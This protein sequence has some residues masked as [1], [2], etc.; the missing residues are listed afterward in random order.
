MLLLSFSTHITA[1]ILILIPLALQ[2]Q[3]DDCK[4]DV[5]PIISA[6]SSPSFRYSLVA[7]ITVSVILLIDIMFEGLSANRKSHVFY[8]LR[9]CLLFGIAA[10]DISIFFWISQSNMRNF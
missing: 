8:F 5:M 6:M 2:W 3:F 4:T 10:P 9:I 1:I 7:G